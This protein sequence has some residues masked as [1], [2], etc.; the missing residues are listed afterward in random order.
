VA[1]LTELS[2]RSVIVIFG[3]IRRRIAEECERQ[4]PFSNG[5]VEEVQ[6]RACRDFLPAPEG[7]RVEV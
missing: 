6:R 2:E 4:S 5:E 7:A 1:Q 3:K